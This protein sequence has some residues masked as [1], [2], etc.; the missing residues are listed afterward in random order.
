MVV[1]ISVALCLMVVGLIYVAV[2]VLAERLLGD[3]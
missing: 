3:L 2:D 1:E